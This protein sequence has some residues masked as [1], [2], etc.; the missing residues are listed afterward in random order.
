VNPRRRTAKASVVVTAAVLALGLSSCSLGFNAPTDQVYN[1]AIGVNETGGNVDVLNA[2]IVSGTDG[3][4]SL[5]ATLANKDPKRDDALTNI[6]GAGGDQVTASPP[7]RTTIPAGGLL[8]LA[9]VG[10][11]A[12]TGGA[13]KSG[14]FVSLT[15]SFAHSESVEVDVPVYPPT[16]PYADL[17]PSA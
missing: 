3:T 5:I 7:S 4:G 10:G 1:P 15:L 14:A 6:S 17:S 16:G 11:A 12:V 13:V 9:D 2:V 8:N